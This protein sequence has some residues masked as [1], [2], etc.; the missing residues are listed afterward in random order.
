MSPVLILSGLVLGAALVALFATAN[1]RHGKGYYGREN[2]NDQAG[3]EEDRAC[4]VF[5]GEQRR[6]YRAFRAM[7]RDDQQH[8]FRWRHEHPDHVLFQVQIR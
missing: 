1:G 4:R 6:D 5:L 7:T 8:Y 2:R 3:T